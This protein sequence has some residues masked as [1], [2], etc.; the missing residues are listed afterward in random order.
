MEVE[1]IKISVVREQVLFPLSMTAN[2]LVQ[3]TFVFRRIRKS[4]SGIAT[5]KCICLIAI[6]I[7]DK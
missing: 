7:P 5:I 4:N 1:K 3:K 2:N 6:I